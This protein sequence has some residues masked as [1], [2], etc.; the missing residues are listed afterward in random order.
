VIKRYFGPLVCVLIALYLS[1]SPTYALLNFQEYASDVPHLLRYVLIPGLIGATFLA[2][3]LFA[4]PRFAAAA[5][6]YGLSLLLALFSFE[7]L[8]TFQSIS[9]QLGM[10]GQVSEQQGETLERAGNTI[11]GFTL[12]RLNRLSGTNDLSKALLSGFPEMK[13]V[14]CTTKD[15]AI[16]YTA[17]RYGFNNPDRLY[18]RP[19]ELMLLGDSFVEGFCL[20]P[21]QDLASQLRKGGVGAASMGIRGNGPL[22]ELATFGRFGQIFRPRHVVLVFF[23]GNDWQNLEA[24]LTEPWLRAAI[25]PDVNFGS[26]STAQETLRRAQIVMAEDNKEQ[27]TV[28]DLLTKTEMLR[29]FVALQQTFTRLGLI[30]PKIAQPMPE[31]RQILHRAKAISQRWDGTFSMVYV[32]R[33]DRFLGAFSS[34][35]AF[36]QLRTIVLDAAGAEGIE[37]IDLCEALGNQHDPARMYAPDGHFS[38]DGA[39]FAADVISR[40]LKMVEQASKEVASTK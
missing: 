20:P 8:L 9:T 31:F 36:D 12:R 35:Q 26:Q 14:L 23:E 28:A 21:G 16:T 18:D 2:V 5:G 40:R 24:E 27:I 7:A 33:V 32:P 34:D 6:A 1:L 39:A 29:N 37:V 3:G 4:K 22:L 25:A 10:L 38:R 17:D 19:L 15:D 30:Y 13:V 11:R